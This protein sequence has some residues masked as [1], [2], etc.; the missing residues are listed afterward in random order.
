M[1]T[2]KN[3]IALLGIILF[4]ASCQA[5]QITPTTEKRTTTQ[6]VNVFIEDVMTDMYLWADETPELDPLTE[7]DSKAYFDKMVYSQEDKWSFITD[8]YQDPRVQETRGETSYQ[9]ID[10]HCS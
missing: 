3:L 7:T 5:E 1:K 6:K 9:E 10:D 8:D 2:L 4:F